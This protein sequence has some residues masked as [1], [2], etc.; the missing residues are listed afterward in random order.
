VIIKDCNKLWKYQQTFPFRR[1]IKNFEIGN[2]FVRI[3]ESETTEF[4]QSKRNKNTARKRDGHVKVVHDWLE[5]ICNE[6]RK[7][8][9]ILAE[10]F[11]MHFARFFLSVRKPDGVNMN[12]THYGD[13]WKVFQDT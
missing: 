6:N 10:E 4:I 11:N 12:L 2:R 5:S 13:S 1:E 9:E 3:S 8:Y 7:I